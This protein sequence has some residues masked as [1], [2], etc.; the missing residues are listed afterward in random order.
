MFKEPLNKLLVF[1]FSCFFSLVFAESCLSDS[2]LEKRISP[3]S[4]RYKTFTIAFQLMQ[5]RNARVL[6][7]TG[8]ARNGCANCEGDGCSTIIFAE[9]SRDNNGFLYSVDIDRNALGRAKSALKDNNRFVKLVHS[10]SIE[11]LKNFNKPIDF[12]YLDSYDFDARNPAPSQNH[13]LR[14][15]IAAYPWLKDDSIVMIDDCALPHG[16]K[17]KLVI[18]FLLSKGWHIVAEGYQVILVKMN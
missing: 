9:W 8:T 4:K 18:E 5:Q 14:E 11:F 15:I 16:G 6:V 10:D 2:Y 7:E 1:S 17:G 3:E 12:L 13:H